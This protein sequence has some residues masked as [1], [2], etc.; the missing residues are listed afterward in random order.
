MRSHARHVHYDPRT[1]LMGCDH[2][3]VVETVDGGTFAF[4]AA[5]SAF[6]RQHYLCRSRIAPHLVEEK[7]I[8]APSF[9]ELVRAEF[10]RR[11]IQVEGSNS[12]G[13][14]EQIESAM[15]AAELALPNATEAEL[16]EAAVDVFA[17]RNAYQAVN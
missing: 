9:A 3:N 8:A 7:K 15:A 4:V 16:I 10:L 5:A 11:G 17:Q 1:R 14:V 12:Q 6:T 13:R 2:C